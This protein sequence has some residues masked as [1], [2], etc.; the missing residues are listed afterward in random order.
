MSVRD[1]EVLAQQIHDLNEKLTSVN[2]NVA[3]LA[4]RLDE[5]EEVN[6]RLEAAAQLTARSLQEISRHWDAVYE[7]MRR[8]M[9]R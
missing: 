9:K 2:E 3:A 4:G 8:G 6:S 5:V 7:A 1:I